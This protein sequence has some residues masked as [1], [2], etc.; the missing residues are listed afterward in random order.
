MLTL[1]RAGEV[2]DLQHG[3]GASKYPVRV[4]GGTDYSLSKDSH[5][6]MLLAFLYVVLCALLTHFLD[7][8]QVL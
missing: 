8:L 3:M 5:L 6:C 1:W 7:A 4:T 2:M